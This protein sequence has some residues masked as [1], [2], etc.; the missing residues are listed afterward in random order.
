MSFGVAE[1]VVQAVVQDGLTNL[2]Q[3]PHHLEYI[4]SAYS[5][6]DYIRTRVGS[7]FIRNAM[8]M[9]LN[10]QLSIRPYYV[11]SI[12]VYPCLIISASYSEDERYF[13]DYGSVESLGDLSHSGSTQVSPRIFAKFSA[14]AVDGD[15]IRVPKEYEI[16]KLVF[17][18]LWVTNEGYIAAIDRVACLDKETVIYLDRKLPKNV[19]L[20]G[21]EAKTL[22]SVLKAA[23]NGSL[24]AV[25]MQMGL[26]TT[27]DPELHRVYAQIIR[28]CLKR[29]RKLF[30]EYGIQGVTINQ[31][32]PTVASDDGPIFR[33]VFSVD[34]TELDTWIETDINPPK[35]I[36]VTIS[37]SSEN[38]KL[39]DVLISDQSES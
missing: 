26:F 25:S 39:Q 3:N 12:D 20:K 34:G 24:N 36:G 15:E 10:S 5:E 11:E 7:N 33:T 6:I 22:P 27:G 23:I 18:G 19:P 38:S 37:A 2:R 13:S 28:Y 29:G 1:L 32:P 21:W 8:D 9:L 30:D 4:L 17:R 35:R 31:Q 16:E 14:T